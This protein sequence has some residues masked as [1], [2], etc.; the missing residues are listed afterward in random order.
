MTRQAKSTLVPIFKPRLFVGSLGHLS[1]FVWSLGMV[2]L[3][4]IK[5]GIFTALLTLALLS[6]FY[7]FAV[8]RILRLRWVLILGSLFLANVF[9]GAQ[10]A[11]ANWVILGLPISSFA[12]I[13]GI[14]MTMRAMVILI[15][16][17]GFSASV[18]IIEVASLLERSG[19][20]GLGFSIGVA[21]NLLPDLRQSS[22][23]V[24]HSLRMRGG[25]RARWW[26]GIQ[27]LFLTVLSNTLRHAD[28]IVLAADVR[29]FRPEISRKI[30]FR[31]GTLDWLMV[32]VFGLSIIGLIT[33]L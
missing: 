29:A 7:P 3:P 15:A 12:V 10:E 8:Q 23:N 16:A 21:T 24:W 32:A 30:A 22:M 17:D 6:A 14:Q 26:R 20:H 1:V 28:E 13:N 27:L 9:F 4:L 31:I 5:Y 18:N 2:L 33:I 19:L 11:R 25:L